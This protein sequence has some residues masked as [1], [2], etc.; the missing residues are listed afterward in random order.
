MN[1]QAPLWNYKKSRIKLDWYFMAFFFVVQWLI[2][3]LNNQSVIMS[4]LVM[5]QIF[6][7][8]R[9]YE[10]ALRQVFLF[11]RLFLFISSAKIVSNMQNISGLLWA[12]GPL[13]SFQGGFIKGVVGIGEVYFAKLYPEYISFKKHFFV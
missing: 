12:M 7:L 9:L 4:R 13:L 8:F 10:L 5:V 6:F 2:L 11:A 3:F 1:Q